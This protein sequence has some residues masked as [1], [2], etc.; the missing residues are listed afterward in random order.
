MFRF[1][2]NTEEGKPRVS[3]VA[4]HSEGMLHIAVARCSARD[5]FIR[6]KGRQIAEGRLAKNKI[7]KVIPMETCDI[8]R[9]VEIAK[10]VTI[11]VNNT[12]QTHNG[13]D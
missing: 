12:K 7:Y 13:K 3:V 11:E 1:Y 2:S 4:Q 9:F 10:Q 8:S 6:K 5:H